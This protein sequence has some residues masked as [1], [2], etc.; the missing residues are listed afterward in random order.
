MGFDSNEA[1]SV[2]V[3]FKAPCRINSHMQKTAILLVDTCLGNQHKLEQIMV[4]Q[5]VLHNPLLIVPE[6]LSDAV[7][8]NSHRFHDS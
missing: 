4:S 2:L 6:H 5:L 7:N 3:S 8:I 1:V